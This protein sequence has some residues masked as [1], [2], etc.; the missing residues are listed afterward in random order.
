MRIVTDDRHAA[1][2]LRILAR[3]LISCF[4]CTTFI[5]VFHIQSG[6]A[7]LKDGAAVASPRAFVG[8]LFENCKQCG[9]GC[10]RSSTELIFW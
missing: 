10:S 3:S 8:I 7:S 2:H 9:F 5:R 6:C 1:T 4:L